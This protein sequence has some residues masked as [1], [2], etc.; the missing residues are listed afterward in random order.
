M[1]QGRL[2]PS[3]VSACVLISFFKL[4]SWHSENDN[5]IKFVFGQDRNERTTDGLGTCD[6]S[7][8]CKSIDVNSS[9]NGDSDS[10]EDVQ[11]IHYR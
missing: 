1:A 8:F 5:Q 3:L 10:N 4:L 9:L 11:L 7:D 6:R 2:R